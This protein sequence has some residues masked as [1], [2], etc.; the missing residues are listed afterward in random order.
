M[1]AA[2]DQLF[3]SKVEVLL[4]ERKGAEKNRAVRLHEIE[5][6]LRSTTGLTSTIDPSVIK[7]IVDKV[8]DDALE[9]YTPPGLDPIIGRI[10]QLEQDAESDRQD[11]INAIAVADAAQAYADQ[12]VGLLYQ[13][14]DELKQTGGIIDQRVQAARDGLMD[15]GG[16]IKLDLLTNATAA[17]QGYVTSGI[18]SYDEVVQGQF[19]SVAGQITQLTAALTSANLVQNGLFALGETGW[20]L[21]AA[22]VLAR[23]DQTGL[24]A[25]APQPNLVQLAAATAASIST[26]LNVFEVGPNDRMQFRFSAAASALRTVTVTLAWENAAGAAV[27]TPSVETLTLSPANSWK[28]YSKQVDPPDTAVGATLTIAKA[29]GG[30]AAL[31]TAIECSTVNIALEA[32]V[33]QIEAAYVD[34]DAVTALISDQVDA[35]FLNADAAVVDGAIVQVIE[36]SAI[37][38]RLEVVETAVGPN[39]SII[40]EQATA[41]ANAEEAIAQ[42]DERVTATYGKTQLV[43]DP[44][45]RRNLDFWF[46]TLGTLASLVV[47]D[48]LSAQPHIAQMPDAKAFSIPP[49]STATRQ[50]EQFEVSPA[51]RYSMGAFYYRPTASAPTPRILIQWFDKAKVYLGNSA[52]LNGPVVGAWTFMALSDLAPPPTAAFGRLLF[53]GNNTGTSGNALITSL[54]CTRMSAIDFVTQANITEL[55]QAWTDP[56]GAFAS[57]VTEV[58]SRLNDPETGLGALATAID[59][60]Y[61][62]AEADEAISAV[63]L[64]LNSTLAKEV[65]GVLSDPYLE[66][67]DWLRWTGA[68]TLVFRPNEKFDIGRTWDFTVTATQQDG[69]RINASPEAIWPGQTNARG[70]V[71]EIDYTLVSGSLNGAAVLL[72]WNNSTGGNFRAQKTLAEMTPGTGLPGRS[73]LARGVFVRPSNFAG[74]FASHNLYVMVNYLTPLAAKRIKIHRVRVRVA[75]EEE[76][77]SGQV[78]AEVQAHLTTNYFTQAQTNQAIANFDMELYAELGGA[79]ATVKQSATA[80]SGL[81]GTVARFRNIVETDDGK[82]AAGIE[83]VAFNNFGGSSGS[84]LKLIGDNIVAKG[85]LSTEKLVVGL[86]KNLLVDP[87]FEDGFAHYIGTGTLPAANRTIDLRLPGQS[88]AHPG[89]PTLMIF[90][91]NGYADGTRYGQIFQRPVIKGTGERAIGVPVTGGKTYFASAYFATISCEAQL[92]IYWYDVNGQQ[93]T[94]VASPAAQYGVPAANRERPDAW[95]RVQVKGLAPANAAYASISF[96]K[97]DTLPGQTGSYLFVWKPQLEETHEDASEPSPWSPGGT[98]TINGARLFSKTVAARH[99]DTE[100]LSVAGLAIFN[101]FL[102]SDDFNAATF[103]GWRITKAGQMWMPRAVIKSAHIEDL[104]VDRIHVKGGAITIFERAFTV[105]GRTVGTATVHQSLTYTIGREGPQ[106]INLSFSTPTTA[107]AAS[108]RVDRVFGP[109]AEDYEVLYA[110]EIQGDIASGLTRFSHTII[111]PVNRSGSITYRLVV[112]RLYTDRLATNPIGGAASN[113]FLGVFNA[114]K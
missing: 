109:G 14:L 110:G 2:A 42:V 66:S 95:T 12:Q 31:L 107:R 62:K 56:E 86:G 102:Q 105:S 59:G 11:I 82:V 39:G 35:R 68:G 80:L 77:G 23:A 3:K 46:G 49:A 111:D 83:A 34:E 51:E 55:K 33:T 7:P 67:S 8:V 101:G 70:Y 30:A 5:G 100:S 75:T 72:D 106:I 27:G 37:A 87:A 21:T 108:I 96:V 79:W 91:N 22:T 24:G 38:D 65:G 69:M 90:Q 92:Y 44:G 4:G 104:A 18:N 36:G 1:S 71:V 60:T 32:R 58:N 63:E 93:L 16:K 94:P 45:F 73:R 78:M 53:F 76:M 85:T 61:T 50:T 52:V 89:W 114:F 29:A 74:T 28:V 98:T 48:T 88:Y 19:E 47:R 84:L 54:T 6:I 112:G 64:E 10:D 97:R 13:D 103:T 40:S 113:R 99:M 17:A 41:I 20:T 15:A 26:D 25:A 43:R 9:G 81:N 57:F